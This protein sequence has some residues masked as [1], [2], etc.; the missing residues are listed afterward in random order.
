MPAEPG[1]AEAADRRGEAGHTADAGTNT[2]GA[3]GL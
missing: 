3:G 2:S 1:Q